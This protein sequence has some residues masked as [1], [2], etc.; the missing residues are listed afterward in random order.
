M[1]SA[2]LVQ[3]KLNLTNAPMLINGAARNA[4]IEL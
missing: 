1:N 2:L 3:Q 4:A